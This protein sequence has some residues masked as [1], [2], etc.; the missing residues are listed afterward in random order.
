MS[1]LCPISY[2][3]GSNFLV[4]LISTKIIFPVSTMYCPTTSR[5]QEPKYI[6]FSE[7]GNQN[8]DLSLWPSGCMITG[9]NKCFLPSACLLSC[10]QGWLLCTC[11]KLWK[12]QKVDPLLANIKAQLKLPNGPPPVF[13]LLYLNVDNLLEDLKLPKATVAKLTT[14]T[15]GHCQRIL[16]PKG[17][18]TLRFANI[19]ILVSFMQWLSSSFSFD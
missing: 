9:I 12:A 10:W 4:C 8:L 14:P 15:I 6:W 1:R 18:L 11:W 16:I 19:A 13:Q 17:P 2:S 7:V 5:C 3:A